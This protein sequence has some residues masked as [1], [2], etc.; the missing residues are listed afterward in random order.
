MYKCRGSSCS[1]LAVIFILKNNESFGHENEKIVVGVP[2]F[3]IINCYECYL[4]NAINALNISNIYNIQ[5][6]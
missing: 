1:V 2:H 6:E 3:N 4:I 5:D